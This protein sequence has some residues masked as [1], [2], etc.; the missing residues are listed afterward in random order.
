MAATSHHL[1]LVLYVSSQIISMSSVPISIGLFGAILIAGSINQMQGTQ[2][3]IL[4]A[5]EDIIQGMGEE[6]SWG[7]GRMD[8]ESNDYPGSGANNRHLPR[9]PNGR[10]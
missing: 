2:T 1:L 4:V 9:P 3:Q 5:S 6:E 8:L 10:G 7:N